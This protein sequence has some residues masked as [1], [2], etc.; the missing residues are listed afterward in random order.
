[1]D[2]ERLISQSCQ[3]FVDKLQYHLSS[4]HFSN[5][6]NISGFDMYFPQNT[7]KEKEFI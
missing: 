3:I 2:V 4:T 7:E 1:M 5:K 6:Y